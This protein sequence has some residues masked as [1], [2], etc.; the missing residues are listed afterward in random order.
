MRF[1]SF[2]RA[3]NEAT[4]LPAIALAVAVTFAAPVAATGQALPLDSVLIAGRNPLTHTPTATSGPGFDALLAA[5]RDAEFVMVGESHNLADLPEFTAHLFEALHDA[6]GFDYLVMEDG[7]RAI[8]MLMAPGIRGD[9]A[10]SVAWA[11]DYVNA[12]QF[13]NDQELDLIADVG[14][15]SDAAHDPVWGV[16]NAWG[17]L[18]IAEALAPLAP[19]PEAERRVAELI[20][21]ARVAEAYRPDQA[22]PRF[23]TELL[24]AD[25][26]DSLERAFDGA[27]SEADKLLR[28]LR[29]GF[30][31]YDMRRDRPSIYLANDLR[32][33]RMRDRFMEHYRAARQAGDSVPRA[34]LKFGQ[35]HAVS[36]PLSPTTQVASLGTFVEE[37]AR[38]RGSE[39]IGIWTTLIN[40]PGDVWTLHDYPDYAAMANAGTT[41]RWW[42]IDLRPIRPLLNAGRLEGVTDTLSDVI[43]GFDF[44]L[45]VGSGRRGTHDRVIDPLRRD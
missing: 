32:E 33:R 1:R 16:D 40:E 18:H 29:V 13:R 10:A 39:M 19:S 30:E 41:D 38:S 44:A 23:I 26:V 11:N 28:S 14:R 45:L 31:T 9:R 20:E 6:Y 24:T 25:V 21:S 4:S 36:G 7:P 27:G 17:V 2:P 8:E 5:A 15:I 22:H 43:Y 35:V 34:V 37:F 42:L 12:L 3:T